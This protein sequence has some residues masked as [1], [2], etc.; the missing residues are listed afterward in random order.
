MLVLNK[1][2]I[3]LIFDSLDKNISDS[4]SAILNTEDENRKEF[5]KKKITDL[6]QIK[7][8]LREVNK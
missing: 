8:K 2:Y 7:T 1:K 5:L 3:G 4:M 6:N